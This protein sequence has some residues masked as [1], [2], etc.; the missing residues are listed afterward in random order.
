MQYPEI[1]EQLEKQIHV[2]IT[3]P[4]RLSGICGD[5]PKEI[6]REIYNAN[7]SELD[8]GQ[9]DYI[10]DAIE[11]ERVY[12]LVDLMRFMYDRR[13]DYDSLIFRTITSVQ[14]NDDN[15]IKLGVFELAKDCLKETFFY[16][17]SDF[18]VISEP[19]R[20]EPIAHGST[21]RNDYL[22]KD[23]NE[24]LP[25]TAAEIFERWINC[26]DKPCCSAHLIDVLLHVYKAARYEKP[27]VNFNKGI[28][29]TVLLDS[30]LL[31]KHFD[32]A[33]QCWQTM[34]LPECYKKEIEKFSKYIISLK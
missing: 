20:S 31:K 19:N 30:E 4:Y 32:L 25:K 11:P 21:A 9:F 17:I 6:L 27:F 5:F 14:F 8:F 29:A 12:Y 18:S 23:M 10:F 2:K 1:F 15:L 16:W 3:R 24:F 13:E 28:F 7:P 34:Q 33:E 22:F 26:F